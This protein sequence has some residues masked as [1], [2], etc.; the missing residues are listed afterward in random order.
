MMSQNIFGK[1]E[2]VLGSAV[3]FSLFALNLSLLHS[4][5]SHSDCLYFLTFFYVFFQH[6]LQSED[7]VVAHRLLAQ[8]RHSGPVTKT[9][10]PS[11]L[12]RSLSFEKGLLGGAKLY[13]G[14]CTSSSYTHRC[15]IFCHL[16]A[17]FEI[18]H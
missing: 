14:L 13:I 12:V 16:F 6:I 8:L 3:G 15:K 1:S 10:M 4:A 17:F 7:F 11:F 2:A 18:K 9:Y 5:F